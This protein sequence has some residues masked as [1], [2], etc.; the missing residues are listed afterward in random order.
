MKRVLILSA[1]AGAG[2]VRAAQAIEKALSKHEDIDVRHE[3]ALKYTNAAFRRM[4]S[5]AYIN[6]VNRAP[7]F[8]GL[9][10]DWADIPW[11]DERQRLAFDR[12]NTLPLVAM[13]NR[14]KPDLVISTHFLP[15][16][17]MS[18]LTCRKKFETKNAVV[19]TDFDVHSMWLCHH[20]YR[21]FVALDETWVHLTHLGFAPDRVVVSGIPVDPVFEIAKDKTEMRRKYGLDPDLPT[22]YMSTGGFGVGPTEEIVMA[23]SHMQHEAQVLAM[24]GRN[25]D[26]IHRLN[27]FGQNLDG[28]SK[29]KIHPV[30]FTSDVDE[31]MA[32]S[33][34]VL[35]KPGGLTTSEALCKG[36]AFC[37]VNPIPGQEERN[38]DHLLEEGAGIRCNNLPTLAYKVDNLIG[39][40]ERFANMKENSLRLSHPD[41]ANIIVNTL[42]DNPADNSLISKSSHK[43]ATIRERAARATRRAT[44][45]I[46]SKLR[47][48]RRI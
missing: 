23:L 42:L 4:Y 35:G 48:R 38:A 41:A 45:T 1:S 13:L 14:H 31:Y 18:W 27:A 8:L 19:V 28:R 9:I 47:R 29:L 21:Y 37:I 5:Q 24:C 25:E 15:A 39:D 17:I 2:H 6:M 20:Y 30:G 10:Y 46:V 40:K 33:D 12:L 16:E 7:Q 36:L 11:K 3:D 22:I 26:L 34:M 44:G 32:A 43:C